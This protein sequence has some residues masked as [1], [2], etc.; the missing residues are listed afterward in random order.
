MINTYSMETLYYSFGLVAL[1]YLLLI[2]TV[3]STKNILVR[4]V[5]VVMAFVSVVCSLLLV[6]SA[7]PYISFALLNL[8]ILH[9]LFAGFTIWAHAFSSSEIR[10]HIVRNTPRAFILLIL[11]VFITGIIDI[12]GTSNTQQLYCVLGISSFAGIYLG[13]LGV[14][15]LRKWDVH[16]SDIAMLKKQPSVTLAIPARNETHALT[17]NLQKAVQLAYDKLEILVVDDCSHDKTAEIIRSFAHSGVRFIKGVNPESDWIGKN[18]AYNALALEA[19][20]EYIAFCG[21][22]I[23]LGPQSIAS[24]ISYMEARDLDMVSVMP[25]YTKADIVHATLQPLRHFWQLLLPM[26][27][28][29][30]VLSSFWVIRKEVLE[31]LGSFKAVKNSVYPERFFAR[32]L[33]G[34]HT[35]GFLIGSSLLQVSTRKKISSQYETS[36]RL[37]Y[38][39]FKRSWV[40]ATMSM[41]FIISVLVAPLPVILSIKLPTVLIILLVISCSLTLTAYALLIRRTNPRMWPLSILFY[42]YKVLQELVLIL[43]SILLYELRAVHWKERNICEPVTQSET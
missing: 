7:V 17:Q 14:F 42:P 21:T 35:Y 38:P 16:P 8:C 33:V 20:G 32:K 31:D 43:V 18:N 10:E 19:S 25:Q 13:M 15:R 9:T 4:R 2:L 11:S 23:E 39:L 37:L 40:N 12:F 3:F 26:K 22:D 29:V 28:H 41:A 24:I 27:E 30:P 6:T 34:I 5:L 36:I 1:S